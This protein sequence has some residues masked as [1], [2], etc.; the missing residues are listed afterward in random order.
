MQLINPEVR[1]SKKGN[2]YRLLPG[3]EAQ[4]LNKT[5][6]SYC[7]AIAYQDKY[8]KDKH[9][10]F[11]SY[12]CRERYYPKEKENNGMWNRKHP[13]PYNRHGD[14]NPK[15]NGGISNDGGY[16]SLFKDGKYIRE[17]R[18]IAEKALGRPLKSNE[19]VHHI[20]LIKTDNRNC[21]LMICDN[22]YHHWLHWQ[23]SKAWVKYVGL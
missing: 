18:L 13:N 3:G 11:C 12:A 8:H 4:Y 23:M 9:K 14:K 16:R 10:S 5:I 17:H 15:W 7:G 6:C 22:S 21:N 19:T 1:I 20:N 2:Y